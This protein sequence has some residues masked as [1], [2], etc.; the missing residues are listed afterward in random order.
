MPKP[1]LDDVDL[2]I[3]SALQNDGR[4][5]N[6]DLAGQLNLSASPCLRRTKILEANGVIRGYR[7]EIDR[8]KVGL[9]LTVLVSLKVREHSRENAE[10]LGKGLLQIPEVV[11]CHMVS[12]EADFFAEVVVAD[13]AAYER[14][15][16]EKI[17]TL[18]MVSDVR[19]NF[20][21]RSIKNDGPLKLQS[22][23]K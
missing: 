15:L 3:L 2:K 9:G 10:Q 4:L 19:S 12:G 21:L 5:S 6:I 23:P 22:A 7:A 11:S 17:L 18:P 1:S 20:V 16:M 14:L 13:L 8:S